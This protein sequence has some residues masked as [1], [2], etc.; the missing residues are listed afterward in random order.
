MYIREEERLGKVAEIFSKVHEYEEEQKRIAKSYSGNYSPAGSRGGRTPKRSNFGITGS[1]LLKTQNETVK[2]SDFIEFK[3]VKQSYVLSSHLL[4]QA[5]VNNFVK[6]AIVDHSE[7]LYKVL[8]CDYKLIHQVFDANSFRQ[9]E[10]MN[11]WNV[12][13]TSKHSKNYC[14]EGLHEN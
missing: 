12:L 10:S 14:F 2:T 9:T 4:Y 6:R 3:Y 13:W 11:E 1:S 5:G 8:N 7:L